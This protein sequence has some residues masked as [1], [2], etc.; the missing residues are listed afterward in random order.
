M[1]LAEILFG[2]RGNEMQNAIRIVA[3]LTM[4]VTSTPV[5][6]GGYEG[7]AASA[8][9]AERMSS[10][11]KTSASDDVGGGSGEP[12]RADARAEGEAPVAKDA[13]QARQDALRER[14]EQEFVREVWTTP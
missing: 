13:I 7:A 10:D 3:C 1:C 12:G 14:A 5:F 8:G 9:E 4:A 2:M 6:A 11:A